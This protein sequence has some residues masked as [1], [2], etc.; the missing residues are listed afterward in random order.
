MERG[1]FGVGGA[2]GGIADHVGLQGGECVRRQQAFEGALDAVGVRGGDGGRLHAEA[3]EPSRRLM[4]SL[5]AT[6][7]RLSSR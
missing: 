3:A 2:Q 6:R 1:A 7:M 5:R 4:Q